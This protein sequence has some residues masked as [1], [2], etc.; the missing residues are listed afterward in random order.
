MLIRLTIENILSFKDRTELSFIPGRGRILPAHKIE[1]KSKTGIK[2]LK[3]GVVYGANASGKSNL[4]KVIDFAKD[5][6]TRGTLKPEERINLTKFKLDSKMDSKPGRLEFEIKKNGIDYAY[7]FIINEDSVIEEWL[8]KIGRHSEK[9]IF[10]RKTSD[11]GKIDINFKGIVFINS[12][13][14]Q[15]LDFIAKSTRPNQ[16]FL[17][18]CNIRNVKNNVHNTEDILNIIDW[19]ANNLQ[20]LFPNSRYH[21]LEFE[22][23]KN[24]DLKKTLCEYLRKFDSGIDDIELRETEFH[25][26]A[27]IPDEVKQD[28]LKNLN[29]NI[30]ILLGSPQKNLRYLISR[31][32]DNSV[33][34]LKLMT[35]HKIKGGNFAY[36]ELQDE[37][38]GTQR[39]FDLIPVLINLL[40]ED[41][42][43]VIDELDRSLH[44]K[45]SENLIKLFYRETKDIQSQLIVTTHETYLLN[46]KL[47][48]KDEIWFIE[49][50]SEGHSAMYSLEEFKPRF[51][52]EVR[53]NYLLGRFGA[54]PKLI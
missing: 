25:K 27:D 22:L 39:M 29:G 51:D 28:V 43:F 37:S 4:V 31:G 15:F 16:L 49:K 9:C 26:I 1:P 8:Y 42:V 32:E 3:G 54:I 48:R 53:K 24:S 41:R 23:E 44:A 13:E 47:F 38:D 19:F 46:L 18:E 17:T 10:E 50:N 21:G 45:L 2:V 5:F 7:G 6:I 34:A 12:E 40:K 52:K 33:K 36:F 11:H 14:K 35:K 20:V 30:K